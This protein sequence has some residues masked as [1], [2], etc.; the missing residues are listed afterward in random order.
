MGCNTHS[1]NTLDLNYL[2]VAENRYN[3]RILT[4]HV[5]DRLVPL[6][7]EGRDDP[8]QDGSHGYRVY[9]LDLR[10]EGYTE[11]S[12]VTNRVIVSAGT[13]GS[14]ELLMRCR[15][16]SKTL[17]RIS[18]ALGRQFSGNGDFLTMVLGTDSAADPN[19]GPVI[20]QATDFN[21]FRD[22]NRE[23]AFILED[24]SYPG[25][26]SWYVEGIK[27]GYLRLGAFWNTIQAVVRR[28][29][30]RKQTGSVGYALSELLKGDISSRIHHMGRENCFL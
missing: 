1:K 10:V 6:N 12:A 24:A 21:L 28:L 14:T 5:V 2:F 16:I 4:E 29:L 18:P 26:L 8:S 20:T 27:P 15:S 9:Y 11:H 3:A 7:A 17:P 23:H 22:F 30:T 13:L 19:Y 25:F